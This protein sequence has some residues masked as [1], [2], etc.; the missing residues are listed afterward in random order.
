MN[1]YIYLHEN[2]QFTNDNIEVKLD[3]AEDTASQPNHVHQVNKN[4]TSK[5]NNLTDANLYSPTTPPIEGQLTSRQPRHV[6]ASKDQINSQNGQNW[7]LRT[8]SISLNGTKAPVKLDT[9]MEGN[10]VD[11][12]EDYE[13]LAIDLMARDVRHFDNYSNISSLSQR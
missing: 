11:V 12:E 8:P 7:L 10:D 4:R 2:H 3:L 9:I 5:A 6:T 1:N 13:D